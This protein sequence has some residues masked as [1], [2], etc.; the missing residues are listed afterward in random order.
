[1][2]RF[3]IPKTHQQEIKAIL[4]DLKQAGGFRLEYSLIGGSCCCQCHEAD[5]DDEENRP[6]GRNAK[7]E[8]AEVETQTESLQSTD[9]LPP[10]GSQVRHPLPGPNYHAAIIPWIDC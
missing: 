2:V 7:R 9:F 3:L 8:T 4:S 6:N 10:Q 5:G 1:M